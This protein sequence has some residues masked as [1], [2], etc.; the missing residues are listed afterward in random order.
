[1]KQIKRS[2]IPL[3]H[4]IK[5]KQNHINRIQKKINLGFSEAPDTSSQLDYTLIIEQIDTFNQLKGLECS[6]CNDK[7]EDLNK[8]NL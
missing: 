6:I 4:S 8:C 2:D 3:L 5:E 7:H 1:M